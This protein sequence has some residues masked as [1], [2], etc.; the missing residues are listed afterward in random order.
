[1]SFLRWSS[2]PPSLQ[3]ITKYD[4]KLCSHNRKK[5]TLCKLLW[6]NIKGDPV[7]SL[8][9]LSPL[10]PN[11]RTT[12]RCVVRIGERQSSYCWSTNRALHFP[13]CLSIQHHHSDSSK[14]K[15]WKEEKEHER[16]QD[17]AG[18]FTYDYYFLQL[19]TLQFEFRKKKAT[20]LQPREKIHLLR[21]MCWGRSGDIT[22]VAIIMKC[23]LY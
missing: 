19:T 20:L 8:K 12:T 14:M 10:S 1:M 21:E 6:K 5:G 2:I 9:T 17:T 23:V 15:N 3:N 11:T 13:S 7:C 18:Y 22:T 4:S 16:R